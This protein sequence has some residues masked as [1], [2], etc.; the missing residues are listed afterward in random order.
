MVRRLVVTVAIL[1]AVAAAL[2]Y[3]VRLYSERIVGDQIQ[4]ALKLDARPSVTFGG[5]PFL[6]HALSGDL[7]SAK[8]TVSEL[9]AQGV[10][11]SNVTL[12]LHDL[13]FSSHRLIT[14]G[15]GTVHARTATIVAALTSADLDATLKSEGI[16]LDVTIHGGRATASFHGA[17]V[18]VTLRLDGDTLVVAPSGAG[19]VSARIGLPLPVKGMRY[20]GLHLA[21]GEVRLTAS[22]KDATIVLR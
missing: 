2:D 17:S 7:P 13:H 3:G 15:S 10:R 8:V 1:A 4:S 14:K 9:S 12:D 18:D 16:P 6:P 11:L 20:T 22:V 5:W 21:G 19:G